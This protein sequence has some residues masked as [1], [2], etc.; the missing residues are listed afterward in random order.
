MAGLPLSRAIDEYLSWLELDRHASPGT[1]EAYRGGD[2]ERFSTF[3][4]DD[5]G[6]PDIGELD[7][8]VLRGYQRHLARLRTGPKEARR[9]RAVSTRSRRLVA[10]WGFPR[11]GVRRQGRPGARR[12]CDRQSARRGRRVPR[13]SRGPDHSPS[14]F[15][16]FQPASKAAGSNRLTIAGAQDVPRQLAHYLGIP[17]FPSAPD[18]ASPAGT[19]TAG[20]CP[21]RHEA[22]PAQSPRLE[23]VSDAEFPGGGVCSGVGVGG[24]VALQHLATAPAE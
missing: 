18:S 17:S 15:I 22:L 5:A 10:L 20:I 11:F 16:A 14:L 13:R 1:V 4:G 2:L 21:Q 24:G 8:D 7:R 19:A 12:P 3:A 6:I 9:P 23:S